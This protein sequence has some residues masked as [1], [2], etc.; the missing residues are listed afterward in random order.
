MFALRG[1]DVRGI[2]NKTV[3]CC[4]IVEV[5]INVKQ[6]VLLATCRKT[7]SQVILKQDQSLLVGKHG[8]VCGKCGKCGISTGSKIISKY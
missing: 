1:C 4:L 3:N 5:L 6:V 7:V 2:P 8:D